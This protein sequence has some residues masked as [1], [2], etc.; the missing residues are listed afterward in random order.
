M[1]GT[2]W[3]AYAIEE[4]VELL[5]VFVPYMEMIDGEDVDLPRFKARVGSEGLP[6]LG[7]TTSVFE[8]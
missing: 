7:V 8:P 1:C 5:D 3:F 4:A 2:G 6:D